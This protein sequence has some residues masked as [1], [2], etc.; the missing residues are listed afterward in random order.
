MIPLMVYWPQL[1]N[2]RMG[3]LAFIP[4][5][6]S[7][8]PKESGVNSHKRFFFSTVE[9]GSTFYTKVEQTQLLRWFECGC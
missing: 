7:L 8:P 6:T 2:S 4:Q 3:E 5:R 1:A 9:V